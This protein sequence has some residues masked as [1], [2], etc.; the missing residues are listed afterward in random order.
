MSCES[1]FS[2]SVALSLVSELI[3]LVSLSLAVA[4]RLSTTVS[5]SA[6]ERIF[7]CTAAWAD[8]L[9]IRASIPSADR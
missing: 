6:R 1:L 8:A 3:A 5:L 9:D 4:S 2:F 7:G